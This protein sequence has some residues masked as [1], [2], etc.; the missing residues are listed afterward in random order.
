[1]RLRKNGLIENTLVIFSSDNGGLSTSEGSPASNLPYRA[2]K[3][4]LYEGGIRVPVL[5]PRKPSSDGWGFL[6][7]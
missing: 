4:W 3:G 2:G 5:V 6:R 7:S 1:M